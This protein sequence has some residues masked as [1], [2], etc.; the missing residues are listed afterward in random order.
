MIR[1]AAQCYLVPVVERDGD[2]ERFLR[3]YATAMFEAE[4]E[5]WWRDP[6]LWPAKRDVRTRRAW[7]E[8]E[9][10]EIVVDL[11]EEALVVE[12]DDD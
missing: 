2:K 7:F 1:E 5:A 4:L 12:E 3:R 10:F 9:F 6:E 8:P 11:C